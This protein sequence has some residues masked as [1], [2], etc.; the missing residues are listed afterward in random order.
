MTTVQERVQKCHAREPDE[1][2]QR[3]Y[4]VKVGCTAAQPLRPATAQRL[5]CGDIV[6]VVHVWPIL[7]STTVVATS[8]AIPIPIPI[9]IPI[10]LL[11]A[12]VLGAAFLPPAL[13][14][15]HTSS[16]SRDACSGGQAI[17]IVRLIDSAR[18]LALDCALDLDRVALG[19][20]LLHRRHNRVVTRAR[21]LGSVELSW[22]T[23][24]PAEARRF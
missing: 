18:D 11:G 14:E 4:R 5:G 15:G 2:S 20:T 23:T 19:G 1:F 8:V 3:L 12:L 6:N 24:E 17:V 16:D 21:Q 13:I 22:R 7:I 9:P 10:A